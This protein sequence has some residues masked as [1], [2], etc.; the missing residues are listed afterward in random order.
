M[1]EI[2][3][4]VDNLKNGRTVMSAAIWRELPLNFGLLVQVVEK[5]PLG[6][7]FRFS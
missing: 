2:G 3:R 7:P 6:E 1:C 4:N 5:M